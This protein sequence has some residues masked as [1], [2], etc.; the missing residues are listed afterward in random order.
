MEIAML[1]EHK[2]AAKQEGGGVPTGA[3]A[4]LILGPPVDGS[5]WRRCHFSNEKYQSGTGKFMM[6]QSVLSP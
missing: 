5:T 3:F 2:D 1:Q 6:K 4:C